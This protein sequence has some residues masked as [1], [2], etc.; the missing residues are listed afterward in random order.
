MPILLKIAP[1]LTA[2][3]LADIAAVALDLH[4]DG[5]IVSNTTIRREGFVS[6][7]LAHETG[8]LSGKPLFEL[9][10]E[11]LRD[12]YRLTKGK[13]P[14]VGVGGIASGADAY[15]KIRSGASL[16]QLY[17]ALTYE[18][19]ALVARIKRDLAA[20]LARDGFSHIADA[21][22]VDAKNW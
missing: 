4:L 3:E 6:G 10:T 11:V 8:G 7:P 20:A 22:G 1:D 21:V 12:I 2:P 18:G 9:S 16:V 17:S 5:L 13:I 19:P 15:A 14:I